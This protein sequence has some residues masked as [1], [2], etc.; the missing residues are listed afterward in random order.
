MKPDGPG[1]RCVAC[2]SRLDVIDSRQSGPTIRRRRRCECCG[3]KMTTF[4]IILPPAH[5]D[6]VLVYAAALALRDRK[7]GP[8]AAGQLSLDAA[9]VGS[10]ADEAP[11]G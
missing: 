3:A 6:A 10:D 9:L 8:T 1:L 4:E 7:A 11:R 5:R 2:Q